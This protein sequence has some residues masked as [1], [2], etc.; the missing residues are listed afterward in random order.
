VKHYFS[1]GIGEKLA[2]D[3]APHANRKAVSATTTFSENSEFEIITPAF[4]DTLNSRKG[5]DRPTYGVGL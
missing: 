2:E 3:N 5:R 1:F 4:N